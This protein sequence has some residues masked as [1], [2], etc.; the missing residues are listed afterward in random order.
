VGLGTAGTGARCRMQ[1]KDEWDSERGEVRPWHGA[2]SSRRDASEVEWRSAIRS[3]I[4]ATAD[5]Q[6]S[7]G[8]GAAGDGP[9]RTGRA[10]AGRAAA[11]GRQGCSRGGRGTR[12]RTDGRRSGR[13]GVRGRKGE[14]RGSRGGGPAP[15][16]EVGVEVGGAVGVGRGAGGGAG[17]G[18]ARGGCRARGR[19]ARRR[20]GQAPMTPLLQGRGCDGCHGRARHVPAMAARHGRPRCARASMPW[21]LLAAR[22]PP[23]QT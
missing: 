15:D 7:T 6:Q 12:G 9:G 8:R 20:H 14:G 11:G 23:T 1:A 22:L 21:R 4:V 10:A 13:E 3:L 2:S 18:R 16:G 5:A 17:M 19:A